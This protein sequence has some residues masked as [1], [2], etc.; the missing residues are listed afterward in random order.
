M[1]EITLTGWKRRIAAF[2]DERGID[3]SAGQ[4]ERM[5]LKIAKR[6]ASMQVVDPD[7]LIRSILDY[8]DPTGEAAVR[9]VMKEAS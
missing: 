7:D 4:I 8:K 3:K 5:A 6:A 2:C 1:P 9:N